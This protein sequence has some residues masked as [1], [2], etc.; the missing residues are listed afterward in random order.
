MT[1]VPDAALNIV[2]ALE[3]RIARLND[4]IA[5]AAVRSG[6]GPDAVRL[7]AATKTLPP[8]RIGEAAAAGIRLFGENFVQE[9]RTK[10]P[11]ALALISQEIE[12]HLIGHLQ[13][14]KARFCPQLFSVVQTVDS[15][16]LAEELGRAA[17]KQGQT[18]PLRILVEVNLSADLSR[19]GVAPDQALDL[20][21]RIVA[22]APELSV[23]GLM[24]IA[25]RAA[26]MERARSSF[27]QLR[28]LWERLPPPN[29]RILSM[30]MSA[31]FEAAIEEGSTL[32]RIGTA[33]F[34]ERPPVR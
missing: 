13:S 15:L 25:P 12:F 3:D 16:H 6:R 31:D 22:G 33:L 32:V 7:M 14:N 23:E 5:H 30:G 26:D 18:Q 21:A 2:P 34:G 19:P 27:Q 29:R 1:S 11:N 24:G 4:R 9:A 17:S 28:S 20:C 10:I 8:E